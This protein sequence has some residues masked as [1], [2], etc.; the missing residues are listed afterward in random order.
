[1]ETGE[2]RLDFLYLLPDQRLNRGK[3]FWKHD[4]KWEAR[5][6][7]RGDRETKIRKVSFC[8]HYQQ[9][10]DSLLFAVLSKEMWL[11]LV[12]FSH[13]QVLC[14]AC[15]LILLSGCLS[16]VWINPPVSC[17]N[18]VKWGEKMQLTVLQDVQCT[19]I[20]SYIHFPWCSRLMNASTSGA[21]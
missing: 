19:Q 2:F 20:W 21:G 4:K 3:K 16:I 7:V 9:P 8:L 15:V 18:S 1:M 13:A 5:L 10:L 17:Q 12:L 14:K 6:R 11:S